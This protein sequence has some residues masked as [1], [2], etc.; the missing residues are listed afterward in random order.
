[1][2]LLNK[3]D[4]N[5]TGLRFAEEASLGVL[6][7]SPI[8]VPLEPNSYADF[9]G[10]IT[11]VARRPINA[12]RQLKKG[13]TVDLDASGGF[14][15]D[16]TQ[17]NL[18]E[19]L[20]GFVFADL[21]T[22]D[23]LAVATVD[24]G[25]T[26]DDYEP[27][28]GGDGYV[29]KDLLFAK[30]FSDAQ[31]NGLKEVSGTPTAT[32]VEVTTALPALS[33]E[34]GTISRVGFEFGS[35]EVD[36]DESSQ[37]LPRLVRV[38]GT[39]DMTDFGLI[40]GEW[41]FLG[42]DLAAE[43]WV[44]AANNGFKRVRQVAATF[45][46]FDKSDLTMVDEVGTALTIRLFLGRVLKNEAQ[47]SLIVRR[48]YN[49]ER[50][51]GAPDDALPAE[52]QSEYLVGSVASEFVLN[53]ATADKINADLS[54]VSIDHE[55][56]TGATGVKSGTRPAITEASAFNTSSDFTRI[57]LASVSSLEEA[58]TA[59]VAFLQEATITINNNVSPNKALATL[60]AFEVTAGSFQIS[61]SLQGYLSTVASIA[62]VRAN[63]D[64]TFDIAIAKENAGMV[65]D[66]PLISLGDGRLTVEL[67][68]PILIPL[69]MDAATA[70]KVA[71]TLDHTLFM[72]FFDFLPTLAE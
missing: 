71:A 40:P 15:S 20:Q 29:A 35:A 19:L 27:A 46:E 31:A 67:D 36:I 9:G 23:E 62:A 44:T 56:R 39:K 43:Q 14:N 37:D 10:E 65:L 63:D 32:S 8:W 66:I 24:T 21:R 7:G 54:F 6:P 25:D 41:V 70:A 42:G 3:I 50:T 18:Q 47:E 1:M 22:K 51:L 13:V 57:R 34:T 72:V 49:L 48:S 16:L 60:G 17:E 33:G 69:S 45:I 52:I 53:L 58:P 38:G 55:T 5:T 59:L 28:A 26:S 4:S 11:S 61:G 12:S 68:E 2:A 30:G 64:I